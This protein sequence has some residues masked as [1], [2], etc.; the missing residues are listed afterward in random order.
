MIVIQFAQGTDL[1]AKAIEWYGHET[2]SHVDSVLPDGRLFGARSDNVGGAPPGV[3]ARE[4]SYLGSEKVFRV[5]LATTADET[6]KYYDWLWTQVGK[7]YDK[8]GILGFIV[9]RDWR[10]P[11]TWFCSELVAAGLEYCEY[12]PYPLAAIT[13]KITPGDLLSLCSVGTRIT[14]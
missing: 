4:P 6:V 10:D 8:Q 5:E 7:P 9:D 2:Y 11:N 1:G 13:N 14:I 12:F 3:Q